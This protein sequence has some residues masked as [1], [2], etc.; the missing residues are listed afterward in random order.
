MEAEKKLTESVKEIVD[1]VKRLQKE[2]VHCR[3]ELCM[4]CGQYSK[5]HLG[6]C[7][8]CRFRH[9]GEWSEDLDE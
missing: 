3:N 2:V 7:D 1:K 6:A 9:G 8:G 4:K 5:A